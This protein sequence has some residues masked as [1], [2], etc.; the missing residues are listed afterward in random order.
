M[1]VN[2][3][4]L[5]KEFEARVASDPKFAADPAARLQWWFERS[6]YEAADTNAYPVVGVWRKTW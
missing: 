5:K 3:P 6:K 4:D 1:M 2:S